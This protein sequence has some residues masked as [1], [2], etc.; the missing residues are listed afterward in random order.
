MVVTRKS[1]LHIFT[2]L[3]ASS[4]REKWKNIM[5]IVFYDIAKC[6]E[7][8]ILWFMNQFFL[9]YIYGHICSSKVLLFVQ[10]NSLFSVDRL[11]NFMLILLRSMILALIW[12]VNILQ[13][14]LMMVLL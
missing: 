1:K 7:S 10:R 4:W 3:L 13:A 2:P 5:S 9:S 11:R 12:K 6:N 14:A 8:F